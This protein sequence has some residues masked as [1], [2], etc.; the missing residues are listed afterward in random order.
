MQEKRSF[1]LEDVEIAAIFAGFR[2]PSQG[3]WMRASLFLAAAVCGEPQESNRWP[4]HGKNWKKNLCAGMLWVFS[5]TIAGGL[6]KFE[7]TAAALLFLEAGGKPA[8]A[9]A[10]RACGNENRSLVNAPL[11]GG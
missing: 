3:N 6:E 4:I 7:G 1:L 5:N 2:R 9:A 11:Q 8:A 10:L